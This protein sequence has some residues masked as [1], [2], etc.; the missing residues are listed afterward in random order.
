MERRTFVGAAATMIVAGCARHSMGVESVLSS[1]A[2]AAPRLPIGFST[3]GCPK[4]D[5]L[6]ALDFAAAHGYSAV[7]LRGILDVMDL[8]KSP[9]FQPARLAQT[10][11]ELAERSLV[12]SDLGA[13]AN[14]HEMEPGKLAAGMAEARGFIDLAAALG[15]PF[16]RVFGNTFPPKVSREKTLEH[17]ARN[18][19]TL[20]EYAQARNVVVLIETH[21]DFIDSP[22]VL[23]LIRRADSPGAQI[24]WD[25]HHTFVI[26]KE[27]PETSVR[28]LGK[29]IRHTHLKD[30]VPAGSDRRYV[31]T[32]TGEVPVRRQVEALARMGY[33]GFYSYEWEK[34]WHPEIEEPDVAF[35]HFATVVSGYLR[36]AGVKA[37]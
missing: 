3:L 4:W 21:G 17:I 30:S 2:S 14:L 8:P 31:L 13:S 22:T 18:L 26:G 35:A 11:R 15:V 23:E 34:R 19:R 16:V 5:W 7:E 32:G 27:S 28:E 9:I 33:R 1:A 29:Y 37:V 24:L 12:I 25:A 20:G 36:D 10:K 6:T